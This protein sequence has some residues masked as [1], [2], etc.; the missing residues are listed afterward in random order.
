MERRSAIQ[1]QLRMH[2]AQSGMSTNFSE[3]GVGACLGHEAL[4][5]VGHRNV[6][7]VALHSPSKDTSE[8]C[9]LCEPGGS[10]VQKSRDAE[11]HQPAQQCPAEALGEQKQRQIVIG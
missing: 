2:T 7:T 11:R 9:K 5:R 1:Q 4:D 8:R 3:S 10:G 6:G